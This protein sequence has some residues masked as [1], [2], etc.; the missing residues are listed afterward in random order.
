[1]NYDGYH[2]QQHSSL[3]EGS[4]D[5]GDLV[6][7]SGLVTNEGQGSQQQL[8]KQMAGAPSTFKTADSTIAIP[9][10]FETHTRRRS[11]PPAQQNEP[12]ILDARRS[13][14][15]AGLY[16]LGK[17]LSPDR[18]SQKGI[19]V[20]DAVSLTDTRRLMQHQDEIC[21]TVSKFS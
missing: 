5:D 7:G 4:E 1:M 19:F 14:S 6:R 9:V 18:I 10:P 13:L 2:R 3:Q 11:A 15:V 21:W 8:P 17:D 20:V 12:L 16:S